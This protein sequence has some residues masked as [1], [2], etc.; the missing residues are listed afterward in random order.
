VVPICGAASVLAFVLRFRRAGPEVRAQLKWVVLAG[1]FLVAAFTFT[2]FQN[3]STVST[4]VWLL[5][6]V[7]VPLTVGIAIFKYRLYEIDRLISRTITYTVL[8][9]MLAGVFVGIV[10]L[11]TRVLPFSSPVAVAASTLAAAA[12]FN[13]LRQR[14][15]QVVDRRFNRARYD[16]ESTVDAFTAQ[17]RDAVDLDE[18]SHAL[19]D[20]IDGG[21][22]PPTPRSGSGHPAPA[23]TRDIPRPLSLTR[24]LRHRASAVEQPTATS[25]CESDRQA[26][27]CG[28]P[29]LTLADRVE[30]S[31]LRVDG[32]E[33]RRASVAESRDWPAGGLAD[34]SWRA[35]VPA[36]LVFV[37][38]CGG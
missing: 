6:M 20:V 36:R 5:S 7:S 14:V 4:V 27:G 2:A 31:G 12:L 24:Q 13:P 22:Q 38:I 34:A 35:R 16:A 28:T 1:A 23:R 11:T 17:L 29:A 30:L 37:G 15:Q 21:V 3:G 25:S 26:S 33:V 8:T 18:V 19:V 10:T 9:A 32:P